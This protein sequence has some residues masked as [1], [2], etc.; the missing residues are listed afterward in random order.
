[1]LIAVPLSD[2]D[3]E[4]NLNHCVEKGADIIELRVDLF[5]KRDPQSVLDCI[6]KVHRAGLKTILTV[7]SEK[8]GGSGIENRLEIFRMCS[9]HSHYTDIEL[10]SQDIISQVRNMVKSAG[11]RLI[12]SYHNFELTPP[13]WILR[14]VFREAKRWGADVVKI[15]V[16]ARSYEDTARLLCLGREEE[17]EKILIAMGEYGKVSRIAG[18]VFGSVISYAFLGS[19]TAPGQLSLEEMVRIRNMIMEV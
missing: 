8:E 7:R 1:M 4:E 3:L 2:R 19:A 11:K 13:T 10:S 12:I 14:E 16:K 15:S 9:P 18:F 17:G 5:E 6:Q